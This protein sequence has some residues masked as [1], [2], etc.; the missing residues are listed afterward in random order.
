MGSILSPPAPIDAGVITPGCRR[1]SQAR[2]LRSATT[3][4]L[5]PA[6]KCVGGHAEDDGSLPRPCRRRTV[7]GA[8]D[9]SSTPMPISFATSDQW[10]S[11]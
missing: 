5:Q 4:G 8:T 3:I 9:K 10:R 6:H 11:G 2:Y 7:G 1:N